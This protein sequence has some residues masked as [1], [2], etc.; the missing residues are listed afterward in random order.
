MPV[1]LLA[2]VIYLILRFVFDIHGQLEQTF[3]QTILGEEY[4][5]TSDP[6]TPPDTRRRIMATLARIVKLPVSKASRRQ[7]V[8]KNT[9]AEPVED[10]QEK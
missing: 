5:S 10:S 8:S 6:T 9:D 7:H 4:T 2:L 3:R 1:L